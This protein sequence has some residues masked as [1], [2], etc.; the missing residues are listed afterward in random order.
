MKQPK[1]NWILSICAP[2]LLILSV[3]LCGMGFS[4]MADEY[5]GEELAVS[6]SSSES[7]GGYTLT[8]SMENKADYALHN[9]SYRFTVPEGL[10]APASEIAKLVGTL[11]AGAKHE[12]T[13]NV[14][15][16]SASTDQPGSNDQPPVTN[17]PGSSEQP[18]DP[19]PSQEDPSDELNPPANKTS[20][21]GM[22]LAIAGGI[23]LVAAVIVT[24]LLLYK[25]K[26]ASSTLSM[27]AI[28]LCGITL[29]G[30]GSFADSAL[31][32]A[33]ATCEVAGKTVSVEVTY[34]P[35]L[36]VE[37]G[38]VKAEDGSI[39]LKDATVYIDSA[40]E[41]SIV[42]RAAGD[43]V[44]DFE[45]VTG[46]APDLKSNLSDLGDRAVIVGTLGNSALIDSLVSA[47][48]LDVSEIEGQWEGYT[49]GVYK[50]LTA[51]LKEAV[52]IAGSDARGTIYGIYEL[53]EQLGVSPWYW[54]ADVPVEENENPTLAV[55][56]L[57]QTEMPDVKFRGI[58][59]NDEENFTFWSEAFENSKT[60][61]GTKTY[62][63]V[64]EL[65]L[66][67]KAN[68]LWPAMHNLTDAFNAV[69]NPETGIAYNA[70]LADEYGIV[71]GS[72]HCELMLCN[73]ETEWEPWCNKNQRKYNITK[74]NN[75]WKE[76][77]D[78]T[79]N[80]EA[81]NAYWEDRVAQNYRFENIYTLGLRGVHDA[82]INCSALTDKS[83]ANRTKV[84]QAA[85][86]AQ[87]AIID[88][89][90][91]KY[92]EETGVRKEFV[93]TYCPY[94]EAAD[95]YKQGLTL[96]EDCVILFCDDNYS[97]VRQFPTDAEKDIYGGFGVY[98]HVS[99]YGVPRSYLWI[100]STPL[101]QIY[102]EMHKAYAAGSDDMWILNVG[103]I[104]PAEMSTDFFMKLAWDD[105]DFNTDNL[106]DFMADF[107]TENY[108]IGDEDA[109]TLAAAMTEFYQLAYPYKADYQGYNEGT[110]YSLVELGDEAERVIDRMTEI[111]ETS[112]AIY[113]KLPANE[114]DSYYQVVH[115]KIRATL[116]TLQK[117]VY[118]QK[119]KLYVSQGRFASV[120]AYAKMSEDAYN[121]IMSDIAYYNSLSGGKWDKIMNPYQTAQWLPVISGAPSVTYL[122]ADAAEDGIGALVEGQS[123][124]ASAVTLYFS[125]LNDEARFL[126]IFSKGAKAYDYTITTDSFIVLE[127]ADGKKISGKTSGGKTTY[128]GSVEVEMRLYLT[129][130]WSKVSKST[131]GSVTVTDKYG[132][133]RT[134]NVKATVASVDPA[135]QPTKGYYE[136]NGLVSMEAEHFT[137]NVS[138]GDYAWV[139]VKDLGFAGDSMTATYQGRSTGP[140][141]DSDFAENGAY[142]EYA[143]YFET[144]GKYN[145]TFY[146][147]PT[148]NE[149]TGNTCRTGYALDDS[150]VNL[151]RGNSVVDTGGSST[152]SNSVRCNME[153]MSFSITV[154]SAGWHTFRIY[155][156]DVGITFDKIVLRHESIGSIS[157]RTGDTET[158]N[159]VAKYTQPLRTTP[160]AISL[161]EVPFPVVDGGDN[162][163]Y[164][165]TSDSSNATEGYLAVD[166]AT[167]SSKG[168]RYS[169]TEG[170]ASIKA[171]RRT[172][173]KISTRD[174]GIL[175]SSS[176]ATFEVSLRRSGSY[177]VTIAVGDRSSSGTSA[178][179]MKV[180]ANGKVVLTGINQKAG[181]TSEYAFTVEANKTITLTFEGTW[182]ISA[183]EII[184][185]EE[186]DLGSGKFTANESGDIGI[187][188][189]T[190][191]ENSQ[192][193]SVNAS[194]DGKNSIWM[195]TGG[196]SGYAMYFGPNVNGS[197]S[198][199]DPNGTQTSKMSFVIDAKAGTYNVW[200]L[201]KS[202]EDDDDSV[203]IALDG[204]QVQTA[205][206][207]KNT[208][209]TFVWKKIGSVKVS[210]DG[211][212][213]FTVWGREDG[214]AIDK[215]V[216]TTKSTAPAVDA[217]M[218]RG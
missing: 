3:L 186:Q 202:A 87:M 47:G 86:D 172:G 77:Y 7:D 53:S 147:I 54:W 42:Q 208:G 125:N 203:I 1:R 193:A 37:E 166:L 137:N 40:S 189:E 213:T 41:H 143:I 83:L 121:T 92:F 27:I 170:F 112:S 205:N 210:A 156:S 45:M 19:P 128:T 191:Q 169:W 182:V 110:E 122:P 207:F 100:D 22:I 118:E 187:E 109:E 183:I 50:N 74:I 145:G 204:G 152:W 206:D 9:V 154:S 94:K 32:T 25:K 188:T 201:V 84:V 13:L 64:F 157:T 55:E 35:Q 10:N 180:T 62:A 18:T 216:L 88:K 76:S 78:Y 39:A 103:D 4:L 91:Q 52:V 21:V 30:A 11:D 151:L 126:D 141:V 63:T 28:L 38:A 101:S 89:Y 12:A 95:Y 173:D 149:G 123:G 23:L 194:K 49:I 133:S 181:G 48:I 178:S 43:L 197:Y 196:L 26:K 176:K 61:P 65:L 153:K 117:N 67:L 162:Y 111:F 68:T 115:Y 130:D 139:V 72:S 82:S 85:I 16:G 6:L 209:G 146:R 198:S 113:D 214:L 185:G 24:A 161:K 116:L 97:Y 134:F 66:R 174:G 217:P 33:T 20:S 184:P 46:T 171:A 218:N 192:F 124:G 127:D 81:M 5:T 120:N 29:F 69:V 104:K 102:N 163:L 105:S 168:A 108:T 148:L 70:E 79:V 119:N 60:A 159:T 132:F 211:E 17:D 144:A 99:Y 15:E 177:I 71:M 56:E 90:E 75:S 150:A 135:K 212:A 129:V 14:T 57:T 131:T 59:I 200:A 136:T 58:F 96:P 175:Y 107:F 8:L 164:D 36:P 73:N 140:R 138:N 80:A 179:N 98:Y 155:Q 51:D 167:D 158:F 114:K 160:P 106:D 190:A 34:A 142:L 199:T 195:Q 93:T 44:S 215:I 2:V 31:Q 165:F